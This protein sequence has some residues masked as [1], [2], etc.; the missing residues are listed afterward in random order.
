MNKSDFNPSYIGPR[1]DIESLVLPNAKYVLDVGCSTGTLGAS[2]KARTGARV[3][4]IELSPEMAQIASLNVDKVFTGDAAEIILQGKLNGYRFDTIIFADLLEHIVDPWAVLKAVVMY[5]EPGGVVIAS[6]PN[7]RHFDTL[8]NLILKGY[9]PYRER[10]IHDRS[11]LRFFTKKN[12][13]ELFKS[14]GLSIDKIKTNYRLIER[15]L[16]LNYF[17]KFFAIPGVKGFLAFQ[18]L[19]KASKK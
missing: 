17:A 8:Y 3:F 16:R 14:A 7:V 11:N 5:L 4:G 18:Y 10:G 1:L 6:I 19:I 13:E 9:W 12:I 15:P 2:I